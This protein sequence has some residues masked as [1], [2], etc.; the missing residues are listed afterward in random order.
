MQAKLDE[1]ALSRDQ[2]VRALETGSAESNN[3]RR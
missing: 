2:H 3:P 1:L